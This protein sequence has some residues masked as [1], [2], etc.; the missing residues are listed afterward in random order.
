[1]IVISFLSII[2]T[3]AVLLSL[4]WAAQGSRLSPVDALF[5]SV[6][7]TCVTGLTVINIAREL[8][9][10]GQL[11]VLV[12]IQLGGLGIMTFSTF[13][14]FLLG[15]RITIR[16]REVLDSTLSYS[17]EPNIRR[18][19]LR[20]MVLVFS[21]E[22]AGWGVLTLFWHRTF[23][24]ARALYYGLFHSVS[25]FCNAGFSLFSTSF[26]EYRHLWIFNLVI[27]VLIVLG[28]LGFVVLLEIRKRFR[29][30]Q[31]RRFSF[32]TR[33]VL[34]VALF[35]IVSGT[36]AIFFVERPHTLKEMSCT[37]G[38]LASL[39]QS[40]TARTAGFNTLPVGSL[41]NASCFI[42]MFLM[43]FGAAPGSCGGGVKITTFGILAAMFWA[44]VRGKEEPHLFNR[45]IPGETVGK[46]MAIILFSVLVLS[47]VFFGLL[48]TE[49]WA[50]S[51]ESSR[52]DFIELLFESFSAFG[53]VGLSMGITQQLSTAGRLLIILLMFV[54][55][56]G[57][58]TLAV[59]LTGS[60]QDG[61]YRYPRGEIMV[62]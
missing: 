18:V 55:R 2:F 9:L 59:A 29:Y 21:L 44:R 61:G 51:P 32:H 62:G 46:V 58:L 7:A 25:A 42:L 37:E 11:V 4:P 48:V 27:M 3:G 33:V 17:P 13:F 38:I 40:I 34:S 31:G 60:D 54:G 10:F 39:F 24:L 45:R 19:L 8:T 41:T 23:G 35:L 52:G 47:L 20:I 6:S 26:E 36:A 53:T 15:K 22:V 30:R 50:R 1:M 28:G 49:E 12:Q 14:L 5:T 43:F 56:L 16:E 57:P